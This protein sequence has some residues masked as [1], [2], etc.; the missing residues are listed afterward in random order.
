VTKVKICGITNFDD[1][2][3]AIDAGADML[4]FNFYEKSPRFVAPAAAK[5]I[6][7]KL[8]RDITTVG[9][10]VN[11]S[12]LEVEKIFRELSLDL[13]Q[14]HGNEDAEF[15]NRLREATSAN[16]IKVLRVSP[17]FQPSIALEYK[18]D[19]FMLDTDSRSFGGSGETF[20]WDSAIRFKALVPDFYLA[21]GLTPDNVAEAIR[22]VRP[23]AVDVCSGVE[24]A[25]G[26]KDA[27][28]VRAFIRNAKDA[29]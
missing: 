2:L 13:V 8:P 22:K 28:K 5:A 26:I 3:M 1:A 14:L 16:V 15:V 24:S 11:S 21:G 20:D 29:L 4:G 23:H 18:A 27:V 17:D 7:E 25:K 6:I 9:V 12:P 10:F 19:H